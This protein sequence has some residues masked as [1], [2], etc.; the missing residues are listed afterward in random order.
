MIRL[1]EAQISAL[2]CAGVFEGEDAM[3]SFIT[4]DQILVTEE[5]TRLVNELSNHLDEI[6]HGSD[7][8]DEEVRKWHRRDA[9]TL[10]NLYGKMLRAA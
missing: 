2:E 5:S 10:S 1:T 4:D 8:R 9:R 6:G 3:R 7:I